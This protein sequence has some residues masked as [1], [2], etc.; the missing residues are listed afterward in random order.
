MRSLAVMMVVLGCGGG[1][2]GGG[3]DV[4]PL[5]AEQA[6]PLC[7]DDCQRRFDCGGEPDVAACT[8]RCVDEVVGWVRADAAVDLFACVAA[9]G[10]DGDDDRC[11]LEV[12]LL[13]AHLEWQSRC[14]ATM[15]EC[16]PGTGEL[17]QNCTIDAGA[18]TEAAFFRLVVPA[19]MTELT[20]CFDGA[21]CAARISCVDSVLEAN[22]INF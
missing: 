20:A 10:C 21:D 16:F 15:A 8:S 5:T 1:G 22:G 19:I 12:S 6:Q 3:G 4:D 11:I 13:D 9:L 7:M 14:L 2:S 18:A 17:E